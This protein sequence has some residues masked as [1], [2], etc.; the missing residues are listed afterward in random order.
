MYMIQTYINTFYW[1]VVHKGKKLHTMYLHTYKAA[2][3]D[4]QCQ[5]LVGNAD[6]PLNVM[7]RGTYMYI[8]GLILPTYLCTI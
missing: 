1:Y 6:H 8:Y 5:I 4:K 3:C 2:D 7:F